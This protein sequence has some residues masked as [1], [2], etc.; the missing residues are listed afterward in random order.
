VRPPPKTPIAATGN[1]ISTN[2]A[3]TANKVFMGGLPLYLTA[4]QVKEVVACF[5]QL[6]SFN[7]PTD[8][9]VPNSNKG[10]AF[11]EYAD[12]SITDRACA[13]L[14]GLR[15]GDNI[16]VVH[17]ARPKDSAPPIPAL[18][19]SVNPL[20]SAAL[21]GTPFAGPT[22]PPPPTH[23]LLLLNMALSEG[24]TQDNVYLPLLEDVKS[25]CSKLGTVKAVVIPKNQ[26]SS[27]LAKVFVQFNRKEEAQRAHQNLGGRKYNGRTVVSHFVD[28]DLFAD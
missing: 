9:T 10:Y 13:S 22:A 24:L 26:A 14:N 23:T 25:E 17:R 3:D 16:L 5:G 6:R 18:P 8:P 4:E 27:A 2:V 20:L 11:F 28:D 19:P 7:L 12:E 15:L 21:L 1:N